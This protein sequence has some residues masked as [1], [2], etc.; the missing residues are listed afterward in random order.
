MIKFPQPT[1]D[2]LD[3]EITHWQGYNPFWWEIWQ[4]YIS[5]LA[6]SDRWEDYDAVEEIISE[7]MLTDELMEAEWF[8]YFD[9]LA[10]NGGF[11]VVAGGGG[12]W[13]LASGWQAT[14][15][16]T[17]VQCHIEKNF[18]EETSVSGFLVF[19]TTGSNVS[20]TRELAL[21]IQ[22]GVSETTWYM[23]NPSPANGIQD[24]LVDGSIVADGNRLRLRNYQSGGSAVSL[25]FTR[26]LI[27]GDGVDPFA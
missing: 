25:R 27:W 15:L 18:T 2:E 16:G 10:S 9:F 24:I 14:S 6:N 22:V 13:V 23:T 8:H 7:L 1:Q 26:L 11:S 5:W 21:T 12:Q 19:F 20:F 4:G 3:H 17:P